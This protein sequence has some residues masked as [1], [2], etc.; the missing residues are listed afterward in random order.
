MTHFPFTDYREGHHCEPR[1]TGCTP[2]PQ[3]LTSAN[4]SE[5]LGKYDR[6]FTPEVVA[7]FRERR[8]RGFGGGD[9]GEAGPISAGEYLLTLSDAAQQRVFR[10]HDGFY[11][12][13]RVPFY[14]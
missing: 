14:P 2:S 9:A 1:Q 13:D 4:R 6:I 5:F 3:S 8:V 12:L 11:R 10:R 7:A